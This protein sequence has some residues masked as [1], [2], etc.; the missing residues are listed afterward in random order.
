MLS[1][2]IV[3]LHRL[4]KCY[5]PSSLLNNRGSQKDSRR[6]F[7]P[8]ELSYPNASRQALSDIHSPVWC[9]RFVARQK[10]VGA[11]LKRQYKHDCTKC[12][13]NKV[14]VE[15]QRHTTSSGSRSYHSS[16]GCSLLRLE[17]NRVGLPAS[18]TPL[19]RSR[20]LIGDK[21]S[22]SQRSIKTT[23]LRE[24]MWAGLHLALLEWMYE[25]HLTP[26]VLTL[27]TLR[28]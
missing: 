17:V 15:C 19:D 8:K 22:V 9:M 16:V 21:R 1:Q 5:G 27:H 26:P 4:Q 11:T 3:V 7:F 12:R 13:R 24:I 23:S 25:T 18:R 10:S 28:T 6:F 2:Q 14:S 20:E